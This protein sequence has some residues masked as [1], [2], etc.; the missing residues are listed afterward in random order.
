MYIIR[1]WLEPRGD[2]RT[3][4]LKT[5]RHFPYGLLVV[6]TEDELYDTSIIWAFVLRFPKKTVYWMVHVKNCSPGLEGDRS[7]NAIEEWE[8]IGTPQYLT[9]LKHTSTSLHLRTYVDIENGIA[10]TSPELF[11]TSKT[12]YETFDLAYSVEDDG[13]D[14]K[15]VIPARFRHHF[16]IIATFSCLLSSLFEPNT[17]MHGLSGRRL[18]ARG[19]D[20]GI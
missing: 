9:S 6:Q 10:V 1:I 14:R 7:K 13:V 4:L 18:S 19:M 15:G 3:L 16:L 11:G 12:K 2:G 8:D 17:Y 5:D 20:G